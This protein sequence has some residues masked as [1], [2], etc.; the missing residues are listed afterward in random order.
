MIDIKIRKPFLGNYPITQV[1][2]AAPDWYIKIAGY[3]HN[4]LD[5]GMPDGTPILAVA[6]GVI[7]YADNV[8]DAD[9]LG[10][11]LGHTFGTSQ[12]W[13]LSSLRAKF[14]Q[15]VKKGDVIGL[16]GHSGWATGP[17]LHFGLKIPA[18]SL[19]VMRGWVDPVPYF[20]T[21]DISPT[22]PVISPRTYLV[23]PGDSLWSISIKFYGQGYYWTKIYQA[24]LDKIKNP[25]FIFPF[26]RLLIP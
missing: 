23:L 4:G 6:D 16:S 15:A 17:H 9:G 2:G 18:L 8:P 19:P 21:P 11:N 14:N 20:D 24:N 5:F 25:T 12:Y 22:P 10:I 7:Q 3:P 1:F 13:H 26:M